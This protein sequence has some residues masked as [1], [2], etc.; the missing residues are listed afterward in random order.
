MQSIQAGLSEFWANFTGVLN[1]VRFR[2]FVDV[3]IV[4]YIIYHGI[5]LVRQT[6]AMQLLK[7][8]AAIL[9]V[10][11]IASSLEMIT[12]NF[13]VKNIMQVSIYI[14][15][16]LFQ[17]ELRSALEQMGRGGISP[18]MPWRS[19]QS[20]DEAELRA[21]EEL[22]GILAD[23]CK[24]LSDRKTGALI[25]VERL[26]K[27]GDVI[28][29]GTL[30]DS[31]PSL[32]LIGNIFFTNSPLHDGALIIR[33]GRLYAAG[34]YL[35]L[36]Q[37]MEIGKE[38]GTRH[39]A[40]LGMSEVSDAIILIVSEETGAITMAADSRLQRGLSPQNLRKL[41]EIKL[42]GPKDQEESTTKRVGFWRVKK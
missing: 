39:R 37:N 9:V 23:S 16:V 12:L 30:I 38:L 4:A 28:K 20:R 24:Y 5:R 7:G 26:T 41:L 33:E 3:A 14:L 17:P 22:I 35:P 13:F 15:V 8:I 40:A 34:C 19:A 2:D 1:S 29:T 6:R 11:F 10:S 21:T 36:S 18:I 32:E 42:I 25:V 31:A 27:L